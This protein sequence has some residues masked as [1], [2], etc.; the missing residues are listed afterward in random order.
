MGRDTCLLPG[1]DVLVEVELKLLIGNIDAEL[2]EWVAAEVLEAK[3]IQDPYVPQ[4]G[5]S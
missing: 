3:D 1:K 4:L 2:L 5:E